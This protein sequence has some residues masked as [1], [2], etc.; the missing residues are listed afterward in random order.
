M[1]KRNARTGVLLAAVAACFFSV[2]GTVS[3]VVL[4]SGVEAT[5]LTALRCLGAFLGL[6][7][8]LL[9]TRKGRASL[10]LSWG[11]VPFIAAYGVLG[12]ALVQWLY[13][14]AI[15][16]L[17]V[18]V[19]LLLEFTAPVFVAL[20]A[21]FVRRERVRNLLWL[22]LGLAL[23]GLALV[24]RVWDGGSLDRVG[25][26]AGLV[27]AVALASYFL[28]GERG[29]TER[30]PISLTCWSMFAAAVF[31]SV[32]KPWWTFDA[33]VLGQSP[34]LLGRLADVHV[35]VW[36]LLISIVVAGTIIPFSLSL[37]ALRHV[38]ATTAGA[39]AMAEPV[40]AGG[41]AWLWLRESLTPVQVA[42]SVVVIA[43]IAL[44]QKA[45]SGRT[46]IDVDVPVDVVDSPGAA[47]GG[48]QL[49]AGPMRG[50][51]SRAKTNSTGTSK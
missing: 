30:D 37:T 24:A 17:P 13:F 18:G 41:V 48:G 42:G 32:L 40:L 25:V 21:R 27:A 19:A 29:V 23:V 47:P 3:K 14:V 43:G 9:M 12:V 28:M 7:A 10:R 35:P 39:V 2:N 44:A 49:A 15:E 5:R 34:S 38:P 8:I 50:N 20:W 6:A 33:S 46:I 1:A 11:E 45:R 4:L 22:A 51:G 26:A 36:A 16:R 31:W